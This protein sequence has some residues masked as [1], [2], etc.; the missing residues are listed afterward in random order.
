MRHDSTPSKVTTEQTEES[1][2]PGDVPM[3]LNRMETTH[4]HE[5]D[6]CAISIQFAFPNR[7]L[8]KESLAIV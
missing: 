7:G 5:A 1:I 4:V 3:A 8:L 6:L 2:G